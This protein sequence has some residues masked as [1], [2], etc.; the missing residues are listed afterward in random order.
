M[1]G[2]VLLVTLAA[3]AGGELGTENQ[4]ISEPESVQAD[5]LLESEWGAEDQSDDYPELLVVESAGMT[6]DD[7]AY[8]TAVESLARALET[9][10]ATAITW[11]EAN[12]AGD[13]RADT[14]RS[15]DGTTT[16]IPYRPSGERDAADAAVLA[17]ATE[18]RHWCI[19]S[20]KIVSMT[21]STR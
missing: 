20:A 7:P 8:H 11:Y 18:W 12:E 13:E 15:A 10:G 6:L 16:L 17:A 21:Q 5:R 1:A 9:N 2:L 4:F 19:S 14:L 3:V